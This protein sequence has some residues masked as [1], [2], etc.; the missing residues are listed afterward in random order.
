[1]G[2]SVWIQ[3]ILEVPRRRLWRTSAKSLCACFFNSAAVVPPD[4]M[5]ERLATS[6]LTIQGRKRKSLKSGGGRHTD[7][8]RQHITLHGSTRVGCRKPK[9]GSCH[10]RK[11]DGEMLILDAVPVN[12]ALLLVSVVC[13][14]TAAWLAVR[15]CVARNRACG[16]RYCPRCGLNIAARMS[17]RGASPQPRPVSTVV[18][19]PRAAASEAWPSDLLGAG[20][21]RTVQP[22]A[23]AAGRPVFPAAGNA[24]SFTIWAAGNHAF[25]GTPRRESFF[26][27]LQTI[28]RE[29]YGGVTVQK[30]NRDPA[31]T[32]EEVVAVA[33]E[34]ER[35]M[36]SEGRCR[37]PRL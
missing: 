10:Y 31:R 36:E 28:L 12:A 8:A 3:A 32:Q 11:R 9:T 19:A 4:S 6:W 35:R 16:V 20:W 29:R 34:A 22:A 33:A 37:T 27:A 2:F 14:T 18:D 13:L 26:D 21:S 17:G 25:D 1:M 15:G 7:S 30:W 23:D 24:R 5:D